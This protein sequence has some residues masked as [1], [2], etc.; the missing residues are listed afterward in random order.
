MLQTLIILIAGYSIVSLVM[1]LV[2]YVFFLPDAPKSA[3]G[4]VSCTVLTASLIA[5]QFMHLKHF[6]TGDELLMH[7]VYIIMLFTAPPAFYF[8]SRTI[9]LPEAPYSWFHF[10]HL[11]PVSI[12]AWLPES[13]VAPIAF[14]IGTGYSIWLA[15]LVYGM[16]R[17]VNRFRFEMFFFGLFAILALGV[18]GLVLL[19]PWVHPERFYTGYAASIGLAVALVTSALLIFPEIVR[20]VAASA[21][22]AY[23]NSTLK[24]VDIS[25]KI[26]AL[27]RLIETDKL[28]RN[29]GLNLTLLAEEMQLSSH[30]MSELINTHYEVGFSRFLRE[31][32]VAD[33][34]VLLGSDHHSSVLSIGLMVGFGS[35]SSFY[36]AF[37]EV[38]GESPAAF[39]KAM[40]AK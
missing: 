36:A 24:A 13:Y 25:A 2:A 34:K 28:H 16:R 19:M 3:I 27:E 14:G 40:A 23:A 18:L 1:L 33:A 11:V 8:F 12:V 26:M 5:L 39:R 4:I 6:N 15:M 20:D 17:H 29:G 30:Q 9:L 7:H 38:V 31:R 32:R 35:Q 10:L 37:R 21:Q 22:L